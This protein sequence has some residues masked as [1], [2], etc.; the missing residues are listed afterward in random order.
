MSSNLSWHSI[1]QASS[2]EREMTK[3]CV[4][5]AQCFNRKNETSSGPVAFL[6]LTVHYVFHLNVL[7]DNQMVQGLVRCGS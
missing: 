6:V 4:F 5:S 3:P 7:A 1:N 2:C